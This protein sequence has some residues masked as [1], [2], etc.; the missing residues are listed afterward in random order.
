MPQAPAGAGEEKA[1]GESG[2]GDE[3]R[4]ERAR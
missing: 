1:R 4:R 2:R 3:R